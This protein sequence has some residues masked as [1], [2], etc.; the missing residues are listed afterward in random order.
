MK[1][2]SQ[3]LWS[4]PPHL[5]WAEP[6]VVNPARNNHTHTMIL[7]H[8]M[9]SNGDKFGKEFMKS[10]QIS[11]HFPTTKFIF[12]TAQLSRAKEQGL[13]GLRMPQWFACGGVLRSIEGCEEQEEGLKEDGNY[14]RALIADEA[15]RLDDLNLPTQNRG[16][17]RIILG[18]LGQ[19]CAASIIV[20][21]GLHQTLGGFVGMSG[22]LPFELDLEYELDDELKQR[23][24]KKVGI[25]EKLKEKEGMK[26]PSNENDTAPNHIRAIDLICDIIDVEQVDKDPGL[27]PN[28]G[29]AG[30]KW[31]PHAPQ[32][33]TPVF[34]GHAHAEDQ[35]DIAR[36][37]KMRTL[38]EALRMR[39]VW[40]EYSQ[41]GH[42]SNVPGE[43]DDIVNFLELEVAIPRKRKLRT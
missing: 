36:G 19:G 32:L 30:F 35:A 31:E 9:H 26:K 27:A 10:S 5:E 15:R 12:P 13:F 25:N 28:S 24:A 23:A 2:I 39:I 8:T 4:R 7:L 21:L 14:I 11:N 6:V 41:L 17:D 33:D 20:A 18:G 29:M 3:K 42:S 38:L 43:I 40:R 34:L 37:R 1:T 22:W 16:Y